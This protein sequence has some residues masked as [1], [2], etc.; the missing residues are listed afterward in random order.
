ME[1]ENPIDREVVR[2]TQAAETNKQMLTTDQK[3]RLKA[4]AA[5]ALKDMERDKKK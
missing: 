4:M 3:R 2:I 5:S 1:T